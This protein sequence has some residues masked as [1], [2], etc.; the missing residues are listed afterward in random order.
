MLEFQALFYI[1]VL[2]LCTVIY[3]SYVPIRPY[4]ATLI[5][6]F[7]GSAD[8]ACVLDSIAVNDAGLD[9]ILDLVAIGSAGLDRVLDYIVI[10]GANLTIVACV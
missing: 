8:L 2:L 5:F 9:Y 4:S 10:G 6:D 3:S 1:F 7:I